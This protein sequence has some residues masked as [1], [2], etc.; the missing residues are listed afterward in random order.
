[1]LSPNFIQPLKLFNKGLAYL[2]LPPPGQSLDSLVAVLLRNRGSAHISLE[3]ME[4]I[5]I[6]E[7]IPMRFR[8]MK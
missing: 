1:M 2:L 5:A 7:P 6:L 8:L 3:T 4:V